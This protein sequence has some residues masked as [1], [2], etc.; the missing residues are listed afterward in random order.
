MVNYWQT[1]RGDRVAVAPT[2]YKRHFR[3]LQGEVV[4]RSAG[5]IDVKLGNGWVYGFKP[6][7]LVPVGCIQIRPD[8]N[9]EEII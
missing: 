7:S 8:L 6:G 3:N 1:R 2:Y 9:L 5:V 4:R